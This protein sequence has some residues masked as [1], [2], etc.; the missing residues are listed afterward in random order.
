MR[1]TC[2]AWGNAVL[3]TVVEEEVS[4]VNRFKRH[5]DDVDATR[6]DGVEVSQKAASVD[7]GGKIGK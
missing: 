2:L 4:L 6:G 5:V 3:K 1:S 7:V